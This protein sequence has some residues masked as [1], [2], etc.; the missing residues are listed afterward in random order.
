LA[1]F[2]LCFVPCGID[3]ENSM[4]SAGKTVMDLKKLSGSDAN[5]IEMARDALNSGVPLVVRLLSAENTGEGLTMAA[6]LVIDAYKAPAGRR[7]LIRQ[8]AGIRGRDSLDEVLNGSDK[9]AK[10][11]AGDIVSFSSSFLKGGVAYVGKATAR[12]HDGIVGK[13]QVVTAMARCS[14]SRVT[15]RGPA[16]SLTIADGDAAKVC[17]T[18]D[19]VV[20]MLKE[21]EKRT[22]I[23]GDAGLIMRNR[24]GATIEWLNG[25]DRD[26]EY[27]AEEL[28]AEKTMVGQKLEVIPVWRVSMSRDQVMREIDPTKETTPISGPVTRQFEHKEKRGKLGFLPCLIVLSSEDEWAFN[29][30]TGKK[31]RVVSGVQPILGRSPVLAN[32]LPSKIRGFD[33]HSN[34]IRAVF[35]EDEIVENAARRA[36]LQP[37][38]AR[39]EPRDNRG[40][41]EDL[42]DGYDSGSTLK[43]GM[44][45]RVGGFGRR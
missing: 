24:E 37:A 6:E 1:Y 12:T 41:N 36:G 33:G 16:H 29:A 19:E 30:K 26:A 4:N 40:R 27:L 42:D 22:S 43:L 25:F 23:G 32:R 10:S 38:P 9:A 5:S 21:A 31:H 44:A 18:V 45:R 28:A 15:K 13:Y 2:F 8:A 17:S 39:D 14:Q 7:V 35:S 34:T 11:V 3:F 20:A